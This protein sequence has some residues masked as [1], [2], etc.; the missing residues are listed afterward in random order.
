[1]TYHFP[2]LSRHRISIT[3]SGSGVDLAYTT[4]AGTGIRLSKRFLLDIS[5]R[6]SD[7]GHVETASGN[8]FMDYLPAGVNIAETSAPLRTHGFLV[9]LRYHF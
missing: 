1:M 4:C 7:L 5:Y 3:P 9:Q 8:M 6:Y 2:G